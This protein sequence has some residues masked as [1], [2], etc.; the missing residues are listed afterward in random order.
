M[1]CKIKIKG[2]ELIS[3]LEHA[4]Q[5]LEEALREHPPDTIVNDISK[6]MRM[7]YELKTKHLDSEAK[8]G[9][10]MVELIRRARES[11]E[12][13]RMREWLHNVEDCIIKWR[14]FNK[15]ERAQFINALLHQVLKVLILSSSVKVEYDIPEPT[16]EAK[17]PPIFSILVRDLRRS[18][19]GSLVSYRPDSYMC[20]TCNDRA[21]H[22]FVEFKMHRSSRFDTLFIESVY[23]ISK[24]SMFMR[25]LSLI[26]TDEEFIINVCHGKQIASS[27]IILTILHITDIVHC[28]DSHICCVRMSEP[29]PLGRL[30]TRLIVWTIPVLDIYYTR[31]QVSQ[32]RDVLCRR[33]LCN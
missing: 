30:N 2:S 7:I 10:K 9:A 13:F 29:G 27:S 14:L 18:G 20:C 22:L 24:F 3:E 4:Y 8:D 15:E 25:F 11:V 21:S 31:D 28:E 16:I 6:I 12:S 17:P 33:C 19:L 32:F 1:L 23:S 5:P 26:T